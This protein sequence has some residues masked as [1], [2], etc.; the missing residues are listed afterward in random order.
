[1]MTCQK[2]SDNKVQKIINN[3]P[4]NNLYTLFLN[5]LTKPNLLLRIECV[6]FFFSTIDKLNNRGYIHLTAQ[7][8]TF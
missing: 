3:T 2:A 5:K 6:K 4:L 7:I 8:L 1:M